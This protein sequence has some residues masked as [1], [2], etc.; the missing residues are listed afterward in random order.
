M[1]ISTTLSQPR[2][3][4]FIDV[5]KTFAIFL[6][7]LGHSHLSQ[8][9]RLWI[10]AFHMP[11]FFAISGFLLSQKHLEMPNKLFVKDLFYKYI[12][13]YTIFFL[14]FHL[15]YFATEKI[16]FLGVFL[17]YLTGNFGIFWFLIALCICRIYMQFAL[18]ILNKWALLILSFVLSI[19]AICFSDIDSI[20]VIMRSSSICFFFYVLGFC[21]KEYVN[22]EKYTKKFLLVVSLIF[23]IASVVISKALVTGVIANLEF[24]GLYYLYTP[25]AIVGII[26]FV[27]MSMLFNS[28]KIFLWISTNTL[29]IFGLHQIIMAYFVIFSLKLHG[30]FLSENAEDFAILYKILSVIFVIPLIIPFKIIFNKLFPKVFKA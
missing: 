15:K 4:D 25:M 3:Y 12:F 29:I 11:L 14:L 24:S 18:K 22:P 5:L 27:G 26:A 21:S 19:V 20:P 23:L 2:R 13:P 16:D 10:Y 6:V 1:S 28:N 9:L 7:I 17:K 8:D 30:M